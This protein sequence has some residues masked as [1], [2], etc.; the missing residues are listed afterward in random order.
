MQNCR[1]SLSWS[2]SQLQHILHQEKR[3]EFRAELKSCPESHEMYIS[4][5]EISAQNES[6]GPKNSTAKGSF[7]LFNKQVKYVKKDSWVWIHFKP[8]TKFFQ[9]LQ[10]KSYTEGNCFENAALA[11]VAVCQGFNLDNISETATLKR[12]TSNDCGYKTRHTAV[13]KGNDRQKVERRAECDRR[14]IC[15]DKSQTWCS[16][17]CIGCYVFSERTLINELL[18]ETLAC[19]T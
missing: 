13:P 16:D 8:K 7:C 5:R 12:N 19:W 17:D 18:D 1:W 2:A 9:Y 3:Q 4:W 11:V 10:T 15:A 14:Y 6:A